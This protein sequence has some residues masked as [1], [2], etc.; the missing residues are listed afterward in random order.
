M[1]TGQLMLYREII[2]VCSAIHT[3]LINTLYGHNVEFLTVKTRQ[4]IKQQLL[5][6]KGYRVRYF[7]GF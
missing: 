3:K 6:F 4:H 7:E 1:R 5:G 2:D